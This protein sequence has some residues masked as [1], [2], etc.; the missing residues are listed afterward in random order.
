MHSVIPQL[1]RGAFGLCVSAVILS[2]C[3]TV[4]R[5]DGLEAV[6]LEQVVPSVRPGEVG[7]HPRLGIAFG[8]GGVRGFVH[9]GVLRAL[10]EADIRADVV[11]GTS[12][13]SVAA[14]LYA[15]GM[16]NAEIESIV[17]AV[18]EFDLADLVIDRQGVLKGQALAKWINGATGNRRI[19]EMPIVLGITVTDL[20][21]GRALLLVDGNVGEAVQTSSSVPGAFVPVQSN[22]ATLVDGGVLSL[23]PVRFARA[24]GADVVVAVDIY[25]GDQQALKG[26]AADTVMKTFRLQGCLLNRDEAAEADFLIRP[27]FEP[28]SATSFAQR[29]EA[30]LAGYREMTGIL[31][32]LKKRLGR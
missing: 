21:H 8:G 12:A 31:P 11:T 18:S 30:I 2:G 10:E 29:D 23:V 22:G 6:R 3:A 15:S 20:T 5:F 28:A 4:N 25:C 7:T 32:E 13:G 1:A 17:R 26:T 14:S 24:L 19:R 16:P 27:H 9:L